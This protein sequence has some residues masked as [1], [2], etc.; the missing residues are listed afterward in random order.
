MKAEATDLIEEGGRVVGVRAKSPDGEI[1]IR[2]DLTVGCDGRHS[3]L[4]ERAG[5]QV[6][7]IGAPM[8]VL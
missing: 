4:R 7:D 3:T 1:E 6:E 8:D 5:F 2:V